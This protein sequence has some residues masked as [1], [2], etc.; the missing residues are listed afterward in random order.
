METT[1]GSATNQN[2]TEITRPTTFG[3]GLTI[4]ENGGGEY[5]LYT[6]E[7]VEI[8]N[9]EVKALFS[10]Y[11]VN[12]DNTII[13]TP[14][15]EENDSY[16]FS[17]GEIK[18]KGKNKSNGKYEHSVLIKLIDSPYI[19]NNSLNPLCLRLYIYYTLNGV[20]RRI[21]ADTKTPEIINEGE[22]LVYRSNTYIKRKF[23]PYSIQLD[24]IYRPFFFNAALVFFDGNL[25]KRRD[26]IED[27]SSRFSEISGSTFARL[28]FSIANGCTI[29]DG[30]DKEG[31]PKYKIGDIN[32]T[33]NYLNEDGVVDPQSAYTLTI[34]DA[35]RPFSEIIEPGESGST[36]NAH[37]R[38]IRESGTKHIFV[39]YEYET[40]GSGKTLGG[41]YLLK[42]ENNDYL[43][44]MVYEYTD[45]IPGS[46]D[47]YNKVYSSNGST[48]VDEENIFSAHTFNNERPLFVNF[49]VSDASIDG[50][51]HKTNEVNC[52]DIRFP[53]N[54]EITKEN[55]EEKVAISYNDY[56]E[57][58]TYICTKDTKVIDN[59]FKILGKMN[60]NDYTSNVYRDD[61]IFN[62][63]YFKH[64]GGGNDEDN[65]YGEYAGE[66]VEALNFGY[67]PSKGKFEAKTSTNPSHVIGVYHGGYEVGNN[68]SAE[69]ENDE[70]TGDLLRYVNHTNKLL[71]MRIYKL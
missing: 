17:I 57:E 41:M 49:S 35:Y 3:I 9:I 50:I 20:D 10:G 42:K 44:P 59:I 6:T 61:D 40:T 24:S 62:Y 54:I 1:V 53:K 63:L 31:L 65:N 38:G 8:T 7:D 22:Y 43:I 68:N 21:K 16:A 66:I 29:R 5:Y 28:Y 39:D 11:T 36:Y 52:V 19:P 2:Y 45:L 25:L 18:K 47:Y 69:N 60:V 23:W 32:L 70:E 46:I 12:D 27:S 26:L 15:W 4:S 30:V 33:I 71:I 51:D 67:N 58:I 64:Y 55:D 14:T 37:V 56:N 13:L 48:L 34:K